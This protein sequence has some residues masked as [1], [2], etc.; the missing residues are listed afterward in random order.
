MEPS[1]Y[2]A[3]IQILSLGGDDCDD[4]FFYRCLGNYTDQIIL[5]G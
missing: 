5:T 4:S 1:M 3:A 2:I